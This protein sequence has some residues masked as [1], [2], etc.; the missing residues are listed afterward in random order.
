MAANTLALRLLPLAAALLPAPLPAQTPAAPAPAQLEA[1]V[2]QAFYRLY[3]AMAAGA[4]YSALAVNG[5][6]SIFD[7]LVRNE[8]RM[9]EL[10]RRNPGLR[11][12]FRTVAV[13]Y[14]KVWMDRS[15]KIMRGRV[16]AQ[17]ARHFTV[18]EADEF[19]RFY[20]SPLGRKMMKAI[21]GNLQFDATVDQAV[22]SG[23]PGYDKGI[24]DKDVEKGVDRALTKLL[25]TLTGAEQDQLLR[26]SKSP[27][28]R[29]IG[30]INQ[31]MDGVPQ[32]GIDEM[33]TPEEREAFGRALRT[34]FER[35][36]AN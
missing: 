20:G 32:P 31:V 4:D 15:T 16:A 23:D 18:T 33:S 21:S 34:L 10:S 35:A 11:G 8:P 9:A 6:D 1:E 26:F 13:P 7:G 17:F 30:L 3:D 25:P 27:A 36:M 14:L 28:F 22:Q 29:K 2:D 19:A 12:E 5:A 24:A